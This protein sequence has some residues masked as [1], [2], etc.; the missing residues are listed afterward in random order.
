MRSKTI[1]SLGLQGM[2]T[3]KDFHL[4][5]SSGIS[6]VFQVYG[7]GENLSWTPSMWSDSVYEGSTAYDLIPHRPTPAC[8]HHSLF[9]TNKKPQQ[10]ASNWNCGKKKK[11][12]KTTGHN[13]KFKR[14]ENRER[15]KKEREEGKRKERKK[16]GK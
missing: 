4:A 6:E 11:K 14:G 12:K 7:G 8:F 9:F 16:K 15:E 10:K 1:K 13:C 2:G 5:G 3:A